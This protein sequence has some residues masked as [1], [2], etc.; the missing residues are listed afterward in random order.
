MVA[1]LNFF[2]IIFRLFEGVGEAKSARWIEA[3]E[4]LAKAAQGSG[5]STA[6]KADFYVK[7]NGDV[8]PATGYRYMD[9]KYAEQT[10]QTNKAPGSYFGFDKFDSASEARDALQ[11]SADWSNAGLRGEFDTLQIIDD[12][13]IPY[14][15]GDTGKL[16]E[17]LTKSYPEFGK[18]GYRQVITNS[19]IEFKPGGLKL[20]GE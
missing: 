20:L 16:L 1:T 4:K 10:F 13:R 2:D 11:I 7:S 15:Y 19:W 9:T 8:V 3:E 18:G 12:I 6:G 5:G 17:P 14:E